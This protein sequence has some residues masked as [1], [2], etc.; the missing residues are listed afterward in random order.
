MFKANSAEPC[1]VEVHAELAIC[2]CLEMPYVGGLHVSAGVT[3]ASVF[4]ACYADMC[5]IA[6][7]GC[8]QLQ[9]LR[10]SVTATFFNHVYLASALLLD[11]NL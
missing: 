9:D 5:L 3:T 11:A 2:A 6:R 4:A 7:P 1:V 10:V 8:C